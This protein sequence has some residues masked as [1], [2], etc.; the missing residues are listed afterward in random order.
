M[1]CVFL[2]MR[3][4]KF[5]IISLFIGISMTSCLNS[6]EGSSISYAYLRVKG[7]MGL[8][9]FEDILGNK[10]YPT[11]SSLTKIESDTDFKMSETHLAHIAFEFVEDETQDTQNLDETTKPQEYEIELLGAR[12]ID[13]PDVVISQTMDNMDEDAPETAPVNTLNVSDGF[14]GSVKPYLYDLETL[15]LPIQFNLSND[16]TKFKM[17]KLVLAC[18]RADMTDGV[19]SMVFYLR[20]DKGEDDGITYYYNQ[21][22]A[23]DISNAVIDFQMETGVTPTKLI[24]KAHEDVNLS[25]E[26]PEEYTEYEIEYKDPAEQTSQN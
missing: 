13:G 12:S 2:V 24:I 9:Y 16:D 23:Y 5:L 7:M 20:H 4:I 1:K 21:W 25:G 22:Y 6:S 10:L 19:T 15:V 26:M 18:C 14:G 8:Y 17:H 3:K 11:T